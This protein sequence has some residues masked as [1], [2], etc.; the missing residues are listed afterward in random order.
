MLLMLAGLVCQVVWPSVVNAQRD[1][2][3]GW[4]ESYM[5]DNHVP[6]LALGIVRAGR[7]VRAQGYGLANLELRVPVTPSTVFESASL[8]K[9]FTAAGILLLV[10]D[11]RLG[12]DDPITRYLSRAPERWR[13]ITIRHL[14]T[15]TSGLPDYEAA[16]STLNLRLDYSEEELLRRFVRF[17]LLFE[18]GEEYS[19]SNTGYA[20]LGMIIRRATGK[21]WDHLLRQRIFEPLGMTTAR[22]ITYD[23]VVPNRADG[24]RVDDGVI[25]NRVT[26]G[27]GWN[28]TADGS[29]LLSVRDLAAW[30]A[31]LLRHLLLHDTLQQAMWSPVRL[32]DGSHTSYGFGWNLIDLP[33]RRAV[34]H[35]GAGWGFKTYIGRFLDDSLTVIVLANSESLDPEAVGHAVAGLVA[36]RLAFRPRVPMRLPNAALA[37]YAG[38][39]RLPTGEFINV[40]PR[41]TGLDF[42]LEDVLLGHGEPEVRDRFFSVDGPEAVAIFARDSNGVIQWLMAKRYQ[43]SPERARRVRE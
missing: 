41:G 32:K 11:G 4:I 31:G 16:D 24:Y 42:F 37:E 20:L 19:Y 10:Q 1:T 30:D 22:M 15:H 25:R 6:G 2:V 38:A 40:R 34:E 7:L 35:S 18:P 39:Y 14:L 12:L 8:G 17:P 13:S 43:S 27:P 9:Q 26:V 23:E 33:G 5:H 28:T 3:D 21:H 36:P 29:L